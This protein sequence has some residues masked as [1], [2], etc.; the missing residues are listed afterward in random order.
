MIEFMWYALAMFI[1]IGTLFI[2]D[3]GIW[4]WVLLFKK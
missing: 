1:I 3:F 4:I 2:I